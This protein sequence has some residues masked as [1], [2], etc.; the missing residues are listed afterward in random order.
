MNSLRSVRPGSARPKSNACGLD[1]QARALLGGG[2]DGRGAGEERRRREGEER[3]AHRPLPAA[4][5]FGLFFA[6]VSLRA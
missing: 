6:A 3:A 5:P 1:A 4:R 2:R